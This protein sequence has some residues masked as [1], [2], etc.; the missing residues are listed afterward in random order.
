[1]TRVFSGIQPTGEQH[2]GNF[3]GATRN[4]AKDAAR[5]RRLLLCG[6]SPRDHHSPRRPSGSADGSVRLAQMLMAVGLDPEVCTLFVQSH[7]REHAEL[8]WIMQCNVSYGELSR[9]TQFKD[10]SG[11]HDFISAGLFTYPALQAADILLYDTDEVPVGDDQRQH[12]EIT[13][14]SPSGSIPTTARPSYCPRRSSPP[15]VP[16]SWTSNSRPRRCR[17]HSTRP[18]APSVSSTS[19]SRSRRRSRAPSPTTTARSVSMWPRSRVSPTCCRSSAP[20]PTVIPHPCRRV[21]A[22]RPAQDGHGCRRHR[23]ARTRAGPLSRTG[24]RSRRNRAPA[25]GRGRQAR[26]I[27][28]ARWNGSAPTSGCSPTKRTDGAQS[29][30]T[31]NN[32]RPIAGSIVH[33]SAGV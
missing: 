17:S 20:P 25:E 10:K 22:V 1:M 16:A 21:R 6:R 4:W 33:A 18:R 3:L 19:R 14:T 29:S 8:G 30:S 27:A 5:D 12:I 28:E 24:S 31:S 23:T 9:M 15:P 7:V 26:E 11:Q 32:T 2:L 13:R